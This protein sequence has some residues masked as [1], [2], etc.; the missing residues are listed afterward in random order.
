MDR[1]WAPDELQDP[2]CCGGM[3]TGKGYVAFS[4]CDSDSRRVDLTIKFSCDGGERWTPV[5]KVDS[6]AGYSDIA[7]VEDEV[8]VFYERF[9]YDTKIVEDLVLAKKKLNGREMVL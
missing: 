9:S 8:Y 5:W 1:V 2:G 3:A 4:N 6:A 7:I